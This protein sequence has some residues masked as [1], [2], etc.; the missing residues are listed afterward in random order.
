[1]SLSEG[2]EELRAKYVEILAMRLPESAVTALGTGLPSSP[3]ARMSSLASRFPGALRELDDLEI[4]EIQRRIERLDAVLAGTGHAELWM[5]ATVLFHRL[6][7]GALWA[8]RWLK[9]QRSVSAGLEA[10]Y[11]TEAQ[12]LDFA[13]DALAWRSELAAIARPPRGRVM[14]L[15]YAR[16]GLALGLTE[17]Q[18]RRVVFG[19]SRTRRE[20]GAGARGTELRPGYGLDDVS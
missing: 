8:K 15:V 11:A 19:T 14:G 13:A 20:I 17:I 7:R 2:I 4:S 9:G 18:A 12:K 3:R 10:S 6:A 5:E 16:I 1:M